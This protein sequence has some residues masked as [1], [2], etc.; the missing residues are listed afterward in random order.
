MGNTRKRPF[1]SGMRGGMRG[2]MRKG[3]PSKIARDAKPYAAFHELSTTP[4]AFR[5]YRVPLYSTHWLVTGLP[6]ALR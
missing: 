6:E 3:A 2:D 1:A 5:W 4:E